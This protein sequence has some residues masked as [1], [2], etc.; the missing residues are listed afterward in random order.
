MREFVIPCLNCF[1]LQFPRTFAKGVCSVHKGATVCNAYVLHL[2]PSITLSL[3]PPLSLS[4]EIDPI[5]MVV[6]ESLLH[7]PEWNP[8]A[9]W[10]IMPLSQFSQVSQPGF[11]VHLNG[12]GCVAPREMPPNHP[13]SAE[14]AP[15]LPGDSS[16]RQSPPPP[17]RGLGSPLGTVQNRVLHQELSQECQCHSY[18]WLTPGR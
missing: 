15:L 11:R 3:S 13:S 6:I 2:H 8:H 10:S 18:H 7:W 16:M 1:L 4:S 12:V 9:S 17:P 5:R 14:I